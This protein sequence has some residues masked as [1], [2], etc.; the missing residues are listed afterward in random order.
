MKMW[1]DLIDQ[2]D[3]WIGGKLVEHGDSMDRA[4]MKE[5]TFPMETEIVDFKLTD[6]W[7]GVVGKDFECGGHRSVVGLTGIKVENGLAISGY[8]GHRFDIIKKGE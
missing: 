7:F 5:G 6:E 1:Q 3:K 8:G 4:L 2:K